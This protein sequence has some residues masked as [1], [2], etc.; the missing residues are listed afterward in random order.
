MDRH[1]CAAVS[2]APAL[3][4]VNRVLVAPSAT[5]GA[6]PWRYLSVAHSESAKET[7]KGRVLVKKFAVT[8][9]LAGNGEKVR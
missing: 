8:P 2:A 3:H 6:T 5:H 1:A 4:W 7:K 9:K